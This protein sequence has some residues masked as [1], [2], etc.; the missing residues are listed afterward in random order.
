MQEF[1]LRMNIS[2]FDAASYFSTHQSNASNLPNI[3]M[4]M[5]GGGY[6]AMLNGAGALKAFDNRTPNTT[7]AGHLGGLLQ[8]TTYLAG[9][10]GGS[11]LVGSLFMNNFT[12]V[13]ALQAETSGSVW[14]FGNSIL[15]GPDKGGIQLLDTAQY[16]SALRD[17]VDAKANAGFELTITDIWGRA[18]SFQLIN[19]TNG[20][21]A[22]TWS[23]IALTE[24]FQNGSTPFPIAISDERAPGEILIAPNTTIYEFNPY[25]MGSWDPTIVCI[26]AN[27]I[28]RWQLLCWTNH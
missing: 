7:A 18:L 13:G 2:N 20:G 14:E 3:G 25:E 9:L 4:A 12:T 24:N 11:W 6:R 16:Y 17:D 15:E 5:S 1:L 27:T 10:S 23:S 21:P 19:A 22:Y 26:R 8:A 28:S